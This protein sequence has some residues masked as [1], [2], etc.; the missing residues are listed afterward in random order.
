VGGLIDLLGVSGAEK[1]GILALE[2]LVNGIIP[3]EHETT[4]KASLTSEHD[5]AAADS[6]HYNIT[7]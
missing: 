6:R 3:W 5:G 2:I 1:D 7:F 4:D